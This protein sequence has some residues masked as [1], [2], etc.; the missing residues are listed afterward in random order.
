MRT[1][2]AIIG[3]GPAG[4]TAAYLLSK[5][6]VDVTVLE[7]DPAYVGGISRTA[8]YKGFHF[9]IGGHRFFSKS[10]AVEDLW[11]EILPNDM[12][13]RPRSSRIF[14]GGKFFAYPLKPFEALIKLGIV[15]STLCLLSWLKARLLPVRDPRNFED[16]VTNQFGRRLFNIFFKSY[17][18]KVWGMSCKEISAD[19]AAQR[20]KG[21]SLGSAIKNAL[22]PQRYNG[23]RTRVIKTLINA[24]RY[25][26]R[27][28]GMMWEACAE[29]VKT[30]GGRIEMACK[31]TGCAYDELRSA[32]NLQFKDRQGNLQS[33]TADHVISSA[34]MRELVRGLSPQVSERTLRAAESLNYRDFLT[35]MLILKERNMFDDNWIYIHD[36]SVKVGRIQNFRSWS[37]EMVPD[38]AKV[39]YGLEYFCFEHDGVWDSKDEDL[40]ELGKRE[41]IKIGLARE[42]DVVDGCVV[43]QKKAYPVYDDDYAQHVATIRQELE[44][45]YPNLH[46]VGRNG[47][48]KYNNQDHAMMTAM[49]CVE[50]I[51]ADTQLYDL[52]QV[53]QD[54][55]YHEAGAPAAEETQGT[56]LRLVPTRVVS[57]SPELAPEG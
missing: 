11:T 8:T 32:W 22:L 50:N 28:P 49:L 51:L 53:N 44:D 45:R 6:D 3:A 37:P 33:L 2:V 31:V 42:G 35:V 18:E 7:A 48:H 16:W 25:P 27:G 13:Q 46:L 12:L 10:K 26:R 36:P 24:F 40:I 34:P 52:W 9:D 17:T 5:N 15:Q 29:K 14:Y 30:R 57:A 41:L 39:C 54:A 20:I 21:L 43:R 56:A 38:P 4:L 55:E 1:N 19:W 47:M 23:D